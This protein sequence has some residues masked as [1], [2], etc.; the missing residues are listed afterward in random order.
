GGWGSGG[1]GSNGVG[2]GARGGG[3]RGKPFSGAFAALGL[4]PIAAM[5]RLAPSRLPA[6]AAAPGTGRFPPTAPRR[7][8]VALLTGCVSPVI[9]PSINA[10][11]IR[12]LTRHGIEVAVADAGCCGSIVPH[13]GRAPD[14][15]SAARP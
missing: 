11:A 14:A 4:A 15:P 2:G 3:G 13:I 7:G 8:R 5:L 12:L 6:K 1:G 10:A 9:A